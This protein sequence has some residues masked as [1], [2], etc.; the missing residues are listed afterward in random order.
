M[1]V[2]GH[3]TGPGTIPGEIL[4]LLGV[5]EM[6][7]Y[8]IARSIR[9]GGS[10]GAGIADRRLACPDLLRDGDVYPVLRRL[11]HDGLVCGRWVEIG[12]DVPRRRYY[13][14]TPRGVRVAAGARARPAVAA[15]RGARP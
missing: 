14:L 10:M 2:A 15:P 3:G 6:H 5:R 12:E 9:T 4:G 11:E 13:T 7:G 8:E 1:R